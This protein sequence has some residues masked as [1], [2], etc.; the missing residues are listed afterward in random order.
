MVYVTVGNHD[1]PFDRLLKE[2]D[3]LAVRL[4]EKTVMQTGSSRHSPRNAETRD[5]YPFNE[6][7]ALIKSASA[8]V[9]HAGI[10]TIISARRH[11]TPLIICPRRKSLGEHF[12]DH[13]LEICRELLAHPRP[14][15]AVAME[16]G[17]IGE[18]LGRVLRDGKPATVSGDPARGLKE[19]I[20][21][22]LV[23]L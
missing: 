22:F 6:A 10:G 13:Q 19:A 3:T 8:V 9:G 17:E 15:V 2:M 11:G 20:E 12:N 5:F 23:A 18:L 16:P 4:T 1:A 14:G 21:N 7:E